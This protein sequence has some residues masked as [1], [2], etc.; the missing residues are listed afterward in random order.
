MKTLDTLLSRWVGEA[1]EARADG[2]FRAYYSSAFPSLARHVQH[3]TGW[4][5]ASA[6]D[7]AQEALVRFFERAGRGRREAV[8]LVR[9]AALQLTRSQLGAL[10]S[11]RTI[12]W[13]AGVSALAG[14]VTGFRLPPEEQWRTA[15]GDLWAQI[16]SLQRSGWRLIDET[17]RMLQWGAVEDRPG[18]G[19]ALAGFPVNVDD[20][21]SADPDEG[22]I[23]R[24]ARSLARERSLKTLRAVVA[25]QRYPGVGPFVETV[26]TVVETLPRLRLPTNGY[27][28]EIATTLF[29]DEIKRRRRKKRGGA[30]DR[31][32][33]HALAHAG[34]RETDLPFE[35]VPEDPQADP[36]DG[37][38]LD[39]CSTLGGQACA[40]A[41]LPSHALDPVVRYESEEFLQ[42]FYEYLRSPVARAVRALEGARGKGRALAAEH[43]L[44]CASR[45]FARMMTVLTMMGEGYTQEET[46]RRTRLSR[47]QVKYIIESVKEAYS[48]FV[49][50]KPDMLCPRVNR[51][52]ESHA[53]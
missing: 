41:S 51:E 34:A 44:E 36:E 1:D 38:W 8:A 9:S 35:N 46:A 48:R 7:I 53:S 3:R 37:I 14:S 30:Q 28:F 16:V 27:L 47:N 25:E 33:V 23:G 6:E 22:E 52:G 45:K 15:A 4:D 21:D 43:R 26:L 24:F 29:L 40:A 13:A 2:A 32:P 39:Q 50:D 31:A 5:P 19:G 42:R 17:R 20:T 10:H 12:R 49:V 11:R 18:E